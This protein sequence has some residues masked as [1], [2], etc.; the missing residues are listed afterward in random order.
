MI[1]VTQSSAMSQSQYL[2]RVFAITITAMT[3]VR[4]F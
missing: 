1:A 3:I 4:I 2:E